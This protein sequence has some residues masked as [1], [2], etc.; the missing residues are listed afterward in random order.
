MPQPNGEADTG[1]GHTALEIPL[2]A[3]ERVVKRLLDA[4]TCDSFPADGVDVDFP[5]LKLAVAFG[6]SGAKERLVASILATLKT[7]DALGAFT[8]FA[9]LNNLEAAKQALK[10]MDKSIKPGVRFIRV[11]QAE[12]IPMPYLLGLLAALE[13]PPLEKQS[14]INDRGRE[15][16]RKVIVWDKVSR[17]FE[18]AK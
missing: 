8:V 9:Q 12:A 1:N 4:F 10:T 17:D 16:S 14:F 18:V 6:C 2:D 11:Q 15:E 7:V 13:S 5:A 3:E